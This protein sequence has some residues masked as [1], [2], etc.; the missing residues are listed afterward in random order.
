MYKSNARENL[1]KLA[2]KICNKIAE[3]S[4]VIKYNLNNYAV[5]GVSKERS[6]TCK[7]YC[8]YMEIRV[9]AQVHVGSCFWLRRLLFY[10]SC[11]SLWPYTPGVA[12]LPPASLHPMTLNLVTRFGRFYCLGTLITYFWGPKTGSRILGNVVFDIIISSRGLVNL[13]CFLRPCPNA[14]IAKTVKLAIVK[15]TGRCLKLNYSMS[16]K[17]VFAING[18]GMN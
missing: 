11:P 1:N 3:L 8:T 7:H 16:T 2:Q 9:T 10:P 6:W 4:T 14:L 12:P 13:K 18:S 15:I 17:K 5:K